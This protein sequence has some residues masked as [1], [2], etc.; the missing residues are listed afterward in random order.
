MLLFCAVYRTKAVLTEQKQFCYRCFEDSF[1]LHSHHHH[2]LLF[3]TIQKYILLDRN[4]PP[5]L[6]HQ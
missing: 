4:N 2:S 3:F 5:S 6:H 1:L